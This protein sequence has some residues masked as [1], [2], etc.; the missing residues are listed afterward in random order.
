MRLLTKESRLQS[1]Q[2]QF[3]TLINS[4]YSR[5]DYKGL[6]FFTKDEGKYFTL[7]VFRDAAS[8]SIEYVNYRT[9]ESRAAKIEQYKN[10]YENR[11]AYKAEQKAKGIVSSHAAAAK[12]IRAELAATFPG[13]KFSVTSETY[14]MGNSVSIDWTD[15]PTVKEVEQFTSKYQYGHFD[16]MTDM[17]EHTNSRDDIP[18]VKYVKEHRSQSEEVQSLK[19]EI[20]KYIH[21]DDLNRDYHNRP[22]QLLYRIFARTS[23]PAGAKI[24]GIDKSGV[25]CGSYED[26]FTITFTAPDQ[27]TQ[28]EQTN[29]EPI[30]TKAGEITVIEYGK[31]IAVLGEETRKIKDKLGRNGLGG[32][33][34]PRLSCGAGWI[35]PKSKLEAVTNLLKE[36]TGQAVK[37]ELKEEVK[38]TVEFF[39][40]T[41]KNIYGEVLP[42]TKAIAELQEVELFEFT[43]S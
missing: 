43:G 29:I 41:D 17:Y 14:S 6:K 24:T 22:E 21:P 13:I 16:G 38:K 34:Q 10:N 20:E 8:H 7:K 39:A 40:E 3:D 31:G 11:A 19:T 30:Q 4:G 25:T 9:A 28:P 33:F 36:Y 26:F 42:D 2:A 1:Q 35:F 32:I 18:Q 37:D 27:P 23:L 5:E 12:A 15:G